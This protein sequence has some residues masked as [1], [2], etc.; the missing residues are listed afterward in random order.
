MP[1]R[2]IQSGSE[3]RRRFHEQVARLILS[4]DERAADLVY[5]LQAHLAREP[6]AAPET[7]EQLREWMA[8]ENAQAILDG[9]YTI[10]VDTDNFYRTYFADFGKRPTSFG[11]TP[12]G[13]SPAQRAEGDLYMA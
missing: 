8:Q 3:E 4:D 12:G 13:T 5:L 6:E 2:S 1:L 11:M 7:S 10:V 9:L